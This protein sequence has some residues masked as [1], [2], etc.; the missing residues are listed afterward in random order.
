MS[1]CKTLMVE[2]KLLSFQLRLKIVSP[3]CLRDMPL[4]HY[5]GTIYVRLFLMEK[6]I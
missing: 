6:L 3:T 5:Y 4:A 1:E 2:S